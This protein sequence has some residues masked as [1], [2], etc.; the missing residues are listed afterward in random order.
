MS[1]YIFFSS[2]GSQNLNPGFGREIIHKLLD[3]LKDL[4]PQKVKKGEIE[5]GLN[6]RLFKS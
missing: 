3:P 1:F 5:L 4:F 2:L 6:E